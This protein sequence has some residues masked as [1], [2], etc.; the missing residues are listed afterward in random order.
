MNFGSDARFDTLVAPTHLA[1]LIREDI[2]LQA[3]SISRMRQTRIGHD[4]GLT[5]EERAKGDDRFTYDGNDIRHRLHV[6]RWYEIQT[7]AYLAR[8]SLPLLRLSYEKLSDMGP[9]QI[10]QCMADHLGHDLPEDLTFQET[11]RKLGTDKNLAFAERFRAENPR[12][13]ARIDAM[14]APMLAALRPIIKKD[15]N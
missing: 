1:W 15:V 14:R 2:V 7:E 4:T 11:H 5:A 3:I 9:M 10:A 6:I 13:I 12:L 8:S